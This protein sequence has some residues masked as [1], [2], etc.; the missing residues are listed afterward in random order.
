MRIAEISDIKMQSIKSLP[1]CFVVTLIIKNRTLLLKLLYKKD[2]CAL[3]AIRRTLNSIQCHPITTNI[4]KF[5]D[6]Q[7][8]IDKFEKTGSFD[9]KRGR[10]KKY[11]SAVEMRLY[12]Y[13]LSVML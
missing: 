6:I 3:L 7:N 8:M 11:V 9:V 2:D 13:R 10:G 5:L 12:K 1:E 4:A